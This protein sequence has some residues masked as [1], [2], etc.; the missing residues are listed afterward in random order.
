[1]TSSISPPQLAR[2]QGD[3]TRKPTPTRPPGPA[4]GIAMPFD[5]T[6]APTARE[7][8]HGPWRQLASCSGQDLEWW[9]A[10]P[11]SARSRAAVTLCRA[12]P[13]RRECLAAGL[14][15]REEFGVWGGLNHLQRRPLL[16]RLLAGEPLG[17]LLAATLQAGPQTTRT[18]AA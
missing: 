18:R 13:V 12:C 1:M 3:T 5:V 15:Y 7:L 14:L 10:K 16:A 17:A 6:G 4:Y 8:A 11:T 9:F 2:Q